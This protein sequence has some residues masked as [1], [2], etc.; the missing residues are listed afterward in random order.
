MTNSML[1]LAGAAGTLLASLA[2]VRYLNAPLHSILVELCGTRERAQFWAVFSN[3][4]VLIVP[5][6]FSLQ[7]VPDAGD[8]RP[9]VIEVATQLKWGL[10]GLLIAVVILGIVLSRFIPR[11]A[12]EPSERVEQKAA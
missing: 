3:V 1:F 10:A 7:Y 2:A 9:G 12:H 8:S 4:A 6:V 5:L 11:P